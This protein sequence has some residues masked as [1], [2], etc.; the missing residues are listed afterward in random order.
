[1]GAWLEDVRAAWGP[2]AQ[3]AGSAGAS[4]AFQLRIARP[5]A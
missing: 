5:A 4:P 3:V 1:V 2:D